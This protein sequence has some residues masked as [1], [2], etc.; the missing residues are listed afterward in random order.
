MVS[1]L[2]QLIRLV[3]QSLIEN[4]LFFADEQPSRKF[5]YV[6]LL[7]AI[8]PLCSSLKLADNI[9]RNYT[10]LSEMC[11]LD[12]SEMPADPKK[13]NEI[14][15]A[16]GICKKCGK[17]GHRLAVHHQAGEFQRIAVTVSGQIIWC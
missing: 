6:E 1:N 7:M 9:L 13:K 10:S 17:I 2:I 5:I 3:Y 4:L 15:T 11:Q 8:Q 12:V 14:L 16:A